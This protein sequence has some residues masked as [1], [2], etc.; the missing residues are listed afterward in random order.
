MTKIKLIN[1]IL[2]TISQLSTYNQMVAGV[3][4]D[5]YYKKELAAE[6]ETL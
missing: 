4:I 3:I 6:L 5:V 2:K 1:K